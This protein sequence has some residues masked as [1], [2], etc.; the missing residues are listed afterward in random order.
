METPHT[1]TLALHILV[2]IDHIT[3]LE[4]SSRL[5][6]RRSFFFHCYN[7][8]QIHAACATD[9]HLSGAVEYIEQMLIG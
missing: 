6:I 2:I 5:Q 3:K 8:F 4:Q 7:I 9:G 1:Y